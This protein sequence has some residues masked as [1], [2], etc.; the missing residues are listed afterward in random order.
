MS[1]KEL[2]LEPSPDPKGR[3]IE[4]PKALIGDIASYLESKSYSRLS[5]ISRKAYINLQRPSTLFEVKTMV[6]SSLS[7]IPYCNYNHDIRKKYPLLRSLDVSVPY[8]THY[9]NVHDNEPFNHL[10]KLRIFQVVGADILNNFLD[11][12]NLIDFEDIRNLT[13]ENFRVCIH[14]RGVRQSIDKFKGICLW[15]IEWQ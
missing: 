12:N 6:P 5:R 2:T 7:E 9:M 15:T 1:I 14:I 13:C 10:Y 3:L 11:S 4:L 8:L